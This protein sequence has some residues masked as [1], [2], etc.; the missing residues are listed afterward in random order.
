M[1][2]GGGINICAF[3]VGKILKSTGARI[4]HVHVAYQG[5]GVD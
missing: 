5:E 4:S 1:V 2:L 3:A